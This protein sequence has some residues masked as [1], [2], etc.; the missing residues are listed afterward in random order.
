MHIVNKV[1]QADAPGCPPT[2]CLAVVGVLFEVAAEGEETGS[3]AQLDK[4]LR[5]QVGD[6]QRENVSRPGRAQLGGGW[7]RGVGGGGMF[8][9][10][11][12]KSLLE[13]QRRSAS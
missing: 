5:A 1:S 8:F 12:I 4:I 6:V 11:P 7:G 10:G 13:R 3:T 2:G 9:E